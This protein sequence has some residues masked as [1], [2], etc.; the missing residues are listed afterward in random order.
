MSEIRVTFG[1]IEAA[2][3][4]V[5]ASAG[6]IE[7]QLADLRSF[8]AP[9]VADWTGAA[10]TNYQGRQREVDT[11]WADLHGVLRQ[12]GMHLGTVND[13]YRATEATNA[14]RWA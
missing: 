2:Q 10:A 14:N 3:Q 7:A 12:I 4:N 13:N 11:S 6:R 8:L 5:V 9:L 1:E